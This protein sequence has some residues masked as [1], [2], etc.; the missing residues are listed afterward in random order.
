M[1]STIP[2]EVRTSNDYI[3]QQ[4]RGKTQYGLASFSQ[5]G[6]MLPSNHRGGLSCL[7]HSIQ[8]GFVYWEGKPEARLLFHRPRKQSHTL[9]EG[10][11]GR[12][13][14]RDSS[15]LCCSVVFFNLFS[16]PDSGTEK[17]PDQYRLPPPKPD[18][19]L[20]PPCPLGPP[21]SVRGR[22]SFTFICRPW[23]SFPLRFSIAV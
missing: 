4:W 8:R 3:T 6:S 15:R 1:I 10:L 20:L 18:R 16:S 7:K 9:Y 12:V 17:Q 13:L 23:R 19:P 22:A 5:V 2:H 11:N 14:T 21:R